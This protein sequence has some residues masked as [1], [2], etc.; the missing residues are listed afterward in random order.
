MV[1]TIASGKGGTGKTIIAT[2]LAK[3]LADRY[4]SSNPQTT[5]WLL[6]CDAEA[7]NAALFVKPDLVS[8]N[9]VQRLIPHFNPDK[10]TGCGQ[11]VAVCTYH[12]IAVVNQ[13]VLFFKELCHACGSCALHCPEG[14]IAEQEE[15]VGTLEKGNTHNLHFA[16]GTLS[17]GFSSPVPVIR[18]LKKWILPQGSTDTI[19]ILDAAPGTSCP[20]V[21]ALRGSDFA[22]LVT[23]PTP[24]GL[25]DLRLIYQL[26]QQALELPCAV[27]INKSGR[28]DCLIEDFCQEK[29][30]PILMRIPLSRTIAATYARGQLLVDSLPEYRDV[31]FNLS[32]SIQNLV[33]EK[34]GQ[35]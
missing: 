33:S 5:V 13:Q 11:C 27:V 16:Q 7:P 34:A 20:V 12:A 6:D 21:E 30:L 10:C 2:N 8:T 14:A 1:I 23:E 25:H 24:F 26:T 28:N 32:E 9:S 15:E 31:F 3:T 29:E 17:I 4:T 19:A 22:L 35:E 18:E